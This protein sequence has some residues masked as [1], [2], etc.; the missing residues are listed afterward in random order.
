ME[1]TKDQKRAL[2]KLTACLSAFQTINQTMPIQIAHTFVTARSK[3]GPVDDGVRTDDRRRQQHR[4]PVTSSI[5]GS[6]TARS[7]RGSNSSLRARATRTC[8]ARNTGS[9]QRAKRRLHRCSPRFVKV[10]QVGSTNA[11]RW[12][13]DRW[14]TTCREIR[15]R[16]LEGG[17]G[18]WGT[19]QEGV[20]LLELTPR[21]SPVWAR[22]VAAR[23]RKRWL[24]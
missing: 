17:G 8:A 1:L 15:S 24:R 9:R 10:E 22:A 6:A 3:R 5:S 4:C 13:S 7:S 12:G 2:L 23:G 16:A 19:T 20:A 11:L 18:W 14:G 21:P